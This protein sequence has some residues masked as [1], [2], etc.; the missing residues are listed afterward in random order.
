MKKKQKKSAYL[1]QSLKKQKCNEQD[2]KQQTKQ[3][4]LQA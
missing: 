1:Q 3:D 2:I 4:Q